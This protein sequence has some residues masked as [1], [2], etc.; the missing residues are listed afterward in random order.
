M[1]NNILTPIKWAG[2]KRTQADRIIQQM[3]DNITS[4][5]ELFLGSGA[6]MIKLLNDYSKKLSNCKHVICSDTNADLIM[7]WKLIK[8]NPNKLIDFYTKEWKERNTYLGK[9]QP[10]NNEGEMVNHRNAHYYALHDKYNTHY[11]KGT[12]DGAMELMTLLAFNFNGLVRYGKKGFNAACM[13]VVPGMHPDN[14]KE[15]IMRCNELVKKYNVQFENIS[16]DSLYIPTNSTIYL[17]PPYKMFLNEN[18][19]GIYNSDEFNLK[20]FY[21]W[22]NETSKDCNMLV[23]FDGGTAGD[24]GFP[25][26]NGWTKITN[27]TGTGKFRRQMSKTREPNKVLKTKESLYVKLK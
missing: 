16:Y 22:C 7:M 2:C 27:D 10:D 25:E 24:E 14:K 12:E 15:I 5:C 18:A 11:L 6:V 23:S 4:Y 21:N 1:K 17:D 19:S 9:L 13:P 20:N 26:C 3:P 8:D